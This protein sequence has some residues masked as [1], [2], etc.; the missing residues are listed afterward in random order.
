MLNVAASTDGADFQPVLTLE[1][2][3]GEFSYPAV[4]QDSD[5]RVHIT[6]TYRRQSIKHVVLDPTLIP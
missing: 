4:I 3:E 6:Y 2:S 5:S 1:R